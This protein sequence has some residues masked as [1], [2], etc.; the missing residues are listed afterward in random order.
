MNANSATVQPEKRAE[1]LLQ[2]HAE[3]L[4][5]IAS[6]RPAG[7]IYD[8][9]ALTY[10]ARHPGLRCSLLELKDGHL[11]HGGAPS[12]PQAYCDAVNGLEYG[13]EVGSCGSA[14]YTGKRVLVESIATDP[15][16]AK[17]KDAALPH[18]M[19]CCWSEPIKD[20]TGIVLGAFGMYYNHE[21]LPN[22]EE[23]SDL[24]SGARLAG[25]VMERD[26]REIALRQSENNYRRLVENLPKRFFLKDKSSTFVTCSSNL[27][28]DLGIA[29]KDIAGTTD[30]DYFTDA[31]AERYRHDDQR[32]MRTGKSEEFE[33]TIQIEGEERIILTVKAPALNEDGE[34]DGVLGFYSDITEQ[35]RLEEKYARAQKMESLG[36]LAGGVAHDLNNVLSMIV[37]YP[38]LLLL[39]LPEESPMRAP[40]ESIKR[41]GIKAA[42]IVADLLTIAR[43]HVVTKEPQELNAVIGDYLG[44]PEFEELQKNHPRVSIAVN[45]SPE[46]RHVAGSEIHLAKVVMNLVSNAFEA[47]TD[48]G[49]VRITSTNRSLDTPIA[50]YDEIVAGEYVVLS[51]SDDGPGISSTDLG[52]IFEPFYSKKVLGR[53][54][55]GLGLTVV[56]NIVKDHRGYIDV[57]NSDTGVTFELY[58]PTTIDSPIESVQIPS[59]SYRGNGERVLIIDDLPSQR[60]VVS[61]MLTQLGYVATVAASGEDAVDYL[62]GHSVDV[63]LLDMIMDPGMSGYETYKQILA[64]HPGQKAIIVSGFSE[65]DDVKKTQALGARQYIKKP[66]GLETIGLALKEEF[67]RGGID[68]P[69]RD[70][71]SA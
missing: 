70:S 3:I 21:A 48:G 10:E 11:M 37:G 19:R 62:K 31:L 40:L 47:I 52:L 65:T 22:E 53:S 64:I 46:L 9:I 54:G 35:K 49:T 1:S 32:V 15:K 56:W 60:E 12:M 36:L 63:V 28:Q 8:A 58:F 26:Q 42:G 34:V 2:G 66:Y 23:S 29:A 51:V 43:G 33:E 50:G 25:I 71:P 57:I 67:A 24:S 69:A 30:S 5:L 7:T 44:S 18:G 17:I 4:E 13:A 6:G 39:E 41:S 61:A 27:A 38:E 55:T 14:T 45:C 68:S 59:D 16:W 20:S